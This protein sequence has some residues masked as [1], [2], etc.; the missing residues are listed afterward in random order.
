M[1]IIIGL[2]IIGAAVGGTMLKRRKKRAAAAAA[3]AAMATPV[4]WG[5][6]Q[7]QHYSQGYN[8]G[9][10]REAAGGAA[11]AAM[12]PGARD[13][14][15]ARMSK[16]APMPPPHQQDP[17]QPMRQSMRNSIQR[18]PPVQVAPHGDSVHDQP[19]HIPDDAI[20][21]ALRDR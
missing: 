3:A 17:R 8:A 18:P 7:H 9:P 14:G 11:A 16:S 10:A 20:H 19:L 15:K 2:A 13:K 5:P 12:A 21:P 6:H 4:A 1:V